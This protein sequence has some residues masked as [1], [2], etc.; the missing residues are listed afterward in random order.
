MK[1]RKYL[2][3]V[4]IGK[5]IRKFRTINNLSIKDL[6]L[7]MFKYGYHVTTK[8]LYKWEENIVTPNLTCISILCDIFNVTTSSFLQDIA[9]S[10]QNMSKQE[11]NFLI[12]FRTNKLFKKLILLLY[13]KEVMNY[14]TNGT[15]I[16]NIK[17]D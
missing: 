14:A 12:T 13:K 9:P 1:N 10:K 5:R 3:K 15:K 4:D 6:Q 8:I 17:K 7:L 2:Y 11:M 16:E